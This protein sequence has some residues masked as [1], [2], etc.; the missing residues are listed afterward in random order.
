[1]NRYRIWGMSLI[2]GLM[3]GL[4]SSPVWPSQSEPV[5]PVDFRGAMSEVTLDLA[6]IQGEGLALLQSPTSTDRPPSLDLGQSS[7]DR[8]KYKT[9]KSPF[10]AFLYSMVIPGTGQLYTGSKLKAAVFLGIEALTLSG[11]VVYHGKGNDKT[12]EFEDFANLHWSE[13]RY[14]YFL[15]RNWPDSD[16][17]D[18]N[19]F[20]TWGNSVF[21]HHLPDSPTQQYY[22]MIGK[23]DQFVFG[24][25]DV[26]IDSSQWIYDNLGDA[27][28]ANRL[29]YEDM[30]HEAN[31]MF[32]RS[33]AALIATMVN[34]MISGVEAALAARN[35]NKKVD[36][37][38]GRLS[39]R[40]DVDCIDED[41]F[42][43]LN[44]TYSF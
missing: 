33:T 16:G 37:N 8:E 12:T 35:H 20:D 31:K 43:T 23:Y 27:N 11:Y 10:K 24:W 38:A 30:R 13:D 3:L 4:L 7:E 41:Y 15:T 9:R 44:M 21:T 29:L 5:R 25:D 6:R 22:E 32:D 1:M 34:H 40:A 26:D 36:A 14:S 18:D 28:S 39:L 42:P 19:V 17:D 2:L